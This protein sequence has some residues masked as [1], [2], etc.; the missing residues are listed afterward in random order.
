LFFNTN[1][2]AQNIGIRKLNLM[3]LK[4]GFEEKTEA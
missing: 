3:A 2:K 1:Q 4:G